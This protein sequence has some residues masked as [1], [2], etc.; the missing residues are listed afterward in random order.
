M[1][2]LIPGPEIVPET[3]DAGEETEDAVAT[4]VGLEP[5]VL[6]PQLIAAAPI[7]EKRGGTLAC[8][9]D[10]L[11]SIRRFLGLSR[12]VE[13]FS[14]QLVCFRGGAGW[15]PVSVVGV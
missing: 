14:G 6:P 15:L 12:L 4:H 3:T 9:T 7:S 5:V 13:A 11:E 2:A 1:S 8:E 10:T